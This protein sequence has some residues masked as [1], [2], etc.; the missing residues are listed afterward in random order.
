MEA[1][2]LAQVVARF[3]ANAAIIGGDKAPGNDS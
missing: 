2:V 3:V 1:T